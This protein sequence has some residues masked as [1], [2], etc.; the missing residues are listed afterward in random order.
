MFALV[1]LSKPVILIIASEL[2]KFVRLVWVV[3][4]VK[5]PSIAVGMF[6]SKGFVP[7]GDISLL[8]F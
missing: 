7:D 3:L 8:W 5:F 2:F 4:I 1:E 6:N